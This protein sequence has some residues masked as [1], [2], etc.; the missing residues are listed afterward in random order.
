MA[1]RDSDQPGCSLV[2]A[3][4]TVVT[5][6]AEIRTDLELQSSCFCRIIKA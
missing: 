2:E 5:V 6:E 4:G 3:M 1:D